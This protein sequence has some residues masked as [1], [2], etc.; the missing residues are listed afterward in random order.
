MFTFAMVVLVM[1]SMCS[2]ASARQAREVYFVSFD[3]SPSPWFGP[4]IELFARA[5]GREIDAQRKEIRKDLGKAMVA[6]GNA[7]LRDEPVSD[8]SF[9]S[10]NK[11]PPTGKG[12]DPESQKEK[13]AKGASQEPQ[14]NAAKSSDSPPAD[15]VEEY[16]VQ[17]CYG[18]GTCRRFWCRASELRQH[19]KIVQVRKLNAK[20]SPQGDPV[21]VRP[22][23]TAPVEVYSA[24]IYSA[25]R[26]CEGC[27]CDPCYCQQQEYVLQR[28]GLFGRRVVYSQRR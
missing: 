11:S 24:P 18:N 9:I 22:P 4:Q 8:E 7:I 16:Y 17:E 20:K 23:P 28:R 21:A 15:E 10:D 3:A 5:V 13:P 25:A 14:K 1:A 2:S 6:A 12:R 27:T 26:C 19:Y